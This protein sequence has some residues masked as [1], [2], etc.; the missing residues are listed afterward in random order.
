MKKRDSI[1]LFLVFLIGV[2][3]YYDY[4]SIA[5]KRPQSVHKW[6]QSDCASIALNYYQ[7]GMNFFV[8]ETHNLTSDGGISGKCCTSEIPVLYYT[9]AI[10]Y[11]I[12][13]Y[14]EPIFRIL[15]MLLFFLGLFY[16]FRLLHYLLKDVFWAITIT[17]LF[18]TSPILVFYG[19]NFLSNSTALAFSFIGWYYFIRFINESKSKWFYISMVVFFLAGALK[20]TAL[21]SL[22][23]ITGAILIET[24]GLTR[25]NGNDKLFKYP[26]RYLSVIISIFILIGSWIVYASIFNQKHDCTYFSTTIFPIWSLDKDGINEVLLNIKGIWLYQYFHLSVL[27]FLAICSLFILVSLRKGNKLLNLS[28]LLIFIEVIVYIILQFRQFRDH[29]YYIIDIFILPVLIVV[30]AFDIIKRHNN[31]IFSSVTAK[32]LFSLF[33]IFNIYYARQQINERYNGWMNDFYQKKDI[34][35][36]TPYLR[37]IG[38]LPNDTVISIPDE[39]NASLYLMNQKGWTEN[40]DARLNRGE[41]V[42]YNQDSAGIQHSIDKGASFLIING[43]KEIYFKPYLQNYCS[44]LAGRYNGILIFNLKDR[45]RNFNLKELTPSKIYSCNAEFLSDDKTFFFNGKDSTFF[46]NG[47]TR[48]DEF[49]H[50][51]QYSSKIYKNS[52]FGM[53]IRIGGLKNGESFAISVWRKKFGTKSGGII[54]SSDSPNAYYNSDYTV[55]ETDK[56][57]WEKILMKFFIPAELSNQ[58]L[59]IYVYNPNPEPA[60]FDDLEIIRYESILK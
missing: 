11:Q 42:R 21:F 58:E 1:I 52:P 55:V 3:F 59:G 54:S 7:D 9:V 24:V 35:S 16:L 60:Y 53:T 4:Q 51:G 8:P 46:Q 43:V 56:N 47:N 49:A 31:R 22:F 10:F 17:L 36:I 25:F 6:R 45:T 14:H 29:D 13:G 19:N 40:T 27:I 30:S 26:V 20:I 18:F 41:K 44:N 2:S 57:G 15:N 50:N 33:L 12:F 5:L 48:S 32:I 23:A 39:S 38:I 28:I 34:Y 37:Q